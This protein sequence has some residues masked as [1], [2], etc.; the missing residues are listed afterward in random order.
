[1]FHKDKF[2]DSDHRKIG[3]RSVLRGWRG[4]KRPWRVLTLG[5][6]HG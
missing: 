4:A 1:M 5:G 3:V 6:E 2:I